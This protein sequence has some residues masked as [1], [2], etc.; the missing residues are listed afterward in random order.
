M[1]FFCKTTWWRQATA[2]VAYTYCLIT[3]TIS[4][5][6]AY[7]AAPTSLFKSPTVCNNSSQQSK[8]LSSLPSGWDKSGYEMYRKRKSKL[9]E[10]LVSD[11]GTVRTHRVLPLEAVKTTTTDYS[12]FWDKLGTGKAAPIWEPETFFHFFDHITAVNYYVG[13]GTWIGPTLFFAAQLVNE[14]YGIEADP[15][16]FADVETNLALNKNS[17]WASQVNLNHHAVG[18]GSNWEGFPINLNMSSASVG[19]SCSGLGKVA[20]GNAKVFWKVDAY[21]L[22]YLLNRWNIP[23]NDV[24]IKVDVESFECQLIPSWLPWLKHIKGKKP[25]FHIAFH[26]QITK[27]STEEYQHVYQF[28]LMFES[29][30]NAC[31]NEDREEWMGEHCLS[32]E[33]LFYDRI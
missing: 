18:L 25:T 19:N 30:D 26:S 5:Q 17:A 4:M 16:A 13:F 8:K 24:F 6:S 20:C 7:D 10:A 3:I 9:A 29:R 21:P 1:G 32:G 33:F 14:A 15:V 22:P 27:C 28:G 12:Y 11:P 2:I 31:M 23:T